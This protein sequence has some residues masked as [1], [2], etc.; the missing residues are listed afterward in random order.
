MELILKA[1][2]IQLEYSGKEILDINDIEIYSYDRIGLIGD[3]GCGKSTLL[4]ILSQKQTLANA[5]LQNFGTVTYIP[6]LE[7]SQLS[8]ESDL[9]L[10][11][12][13]GVSNLNQDT[14]SGGE[15]TRMKIVTAFSKQAHALFIDEPT[16]HLDEEGINLLIK[17]IDA[18]EGALLVVSHDRYFLDSVVDKIWELK[19]GK[20]TE[21]W[22][23]YSEYSQQKQEQHMHQAEEYKKIEKERKRLELSMME[24]QKQA[25]QIDKKSK[26][27]VKKNANESA[28]RLGYQKS[29]GTKQK[30]LFNAAKNL[31]K[32]ITALDDISAP[33]NKRT[34]RFK[35]SEALALHNKCPIMG[36]EINL[37]FGE[38]IIFKNANIN[39]PLGAK[40][41]ITGANGTGKTSLFK[42]ILENAEGFN[43][44]P[45]AVIGYLKQTGYQLTDNQS[46]I[47]F[48]QEDCD[49]QIPE[50][51]SALAAMGF[52]PR[53][54]N[55]NLS[56]LSGGEIIKILLTKVLLARYNILLLDEPSNYLD[57]SSIEALENMMQNYAG[58]IVF[59]SHDKRLVE[60]VATIIYEIKDKAIT[61]I[62][63]KQ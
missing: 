15:E 39:I 45:K 7:R 46:I 49:Y 27:A 18:F 13:F 36:N 60:N 31:E 37:T 61:K 29:T 4:N 59:I 23:G 5:K 12:R 43:I 20:I 25:Q 40:V 33:E 57:I 32:R 50:I 56:V 10:L 21:Y 55:K 52:G 48:M 17:N 2:N 42:M 11:S 44:S 54:I 1:E 9:S 22:G 6:Q 19:D 41:A 3:N 34:V 16:C 28:G 14:M 30:K 53:D 24:K 63:D 38:K 35:Q 26:G 47:S 51:R 62:Y 58:T 8:E